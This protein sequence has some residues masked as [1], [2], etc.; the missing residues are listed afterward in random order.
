MI[1]RSSPDENYMEK[2]GIWKVFIGQ[3]WEGLP[4]SFT[5]ILLSRTQYYDHVSLARGLGNMVPS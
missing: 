4:I 5:H 3:A 2:G 1:F